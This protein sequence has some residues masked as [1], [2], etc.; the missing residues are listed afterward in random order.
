MLE[1]IG[2]RSHHSI[3]VYPGGIKYLPSNEDLQKVR[4]QAEEAKKDAYETIRL[5]SEFG[6]G[7]GRQ[8]D[9]VALVNDDYNFLEGDIA[10]SSGM[11]IPESSYLKHVEEFIV[12]YSLAKQAKFEGKEFMVGALARMN[13]N[14]QKMT[15]ETKKI[16]K[17]FSLKFPSHSSFMNNTA[18]AVEIYNCL[19]STIRL[20]DELKLRHEEIPKLKRPKNEDGIGVTEAPRGTLYHGYKISKEGIVK[21]GNIIVPTSQNARAIEKDIEHYIPSLLDLPQEKI[22]LELEKLVRAYDPCISCATH[23]LKVNWE[24]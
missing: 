16:V 3:N 4:K 19:D 8:T 20:I 1:L 11:R 21:D 24:K 6:N 15:E 7:F 23:F 17:E 9:Y 10:S 14:R 22:E 18:Q 12:P 13:I 2:G 5:F